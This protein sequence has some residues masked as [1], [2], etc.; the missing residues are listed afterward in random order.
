MKEA[1]IR[2]EQERVE[3]EAKEKAEEE[4]SKTKY[5]EMLAR[6][7]K[8]LRG[9]PEIA[10]KPTSVENIFAKFRETED[11]VSSFTR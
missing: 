4:A 7:P 10:K 3:R 5:A 1:E 2:R 9:E 11:E 8:E 6:I